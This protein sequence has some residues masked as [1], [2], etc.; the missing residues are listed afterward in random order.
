MRF[1]RKNKKKIIL[2]PFFSLCLFSCSFYDE[3]VRGYFEYW[4]GTVQVGRIDVETPHKKIGS[5]ENVSAKD[6]TEFSLCIINAQSYPL[7]EKPDGGGSCC[8]I[9]DLEENTAFESFEETLVSSDLVSVKA[10]LLDENEGKTLVLKGNLYPKDMSQLW[11]E[12]EFS[13]SFVQN[14]PPDEV[15]NLDATKKDFLGN[16]QHYVSFR[17]P[18]QSRKRNQ[19]ISHYEIGCYLKENGS[20]VFKGKTAVPPEKNMNPDRTSNEFQ[21]CFPFQEENL[22]YDYTVTAVDR[23]NLKSETIS[24]DP[25]IGVK[26]AAEAKI[27]FN[28]EPNGFSDSDGY[29]YFELDSLSSI[30]CEIKKSDEGDILSGTVDGIPYS[31]NHVG[32]LETG[33]HVIT[34]TIQHDGCRT[35]EI[36][37]KIKVVESIR[38]SIYDFTDAEFSSDVCEPGFKTYDCAAGSESASFNLYSSESGISMSGTVDG[39]P[40]TGPLSSRNLGL[41]PHVIN[42]QICKDMRRTKNEEIKIYVRGIFEE[43]EIS[44][45]ATSTAEF[46]DGYEIMK[47]SYRNYD[48][49]PYVVDAKNDNATVSIKIDGASYNSTGVIDF[50]KHVVDIKLTGT[51]WKTFEMQK[52]IYVRMKTLKLKIGSGVSASH[53]YINPT[54]FGKNTWDLKGW[55]KINELLLFSYEKGSVGVTQGIY[56]EIYDNAYSIAVPLEN[57]SDPVTCM[58][59]E[60][61]RNIGV[62]NDKT[63]FDDKGWHFAGSMNLREIKANGWVLE[64]PILNGQN[65][66][67]IKLKFQFFPVEDD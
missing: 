48:K 51:Y 28:I 31:G 62:G 30:T 29:E 59:S 37:K 24:T 38:S 7:L 2:I 50:G 4:T 6:G 39:E 49:M 13:W 60:I 17:I 22:Y 8:T 20:L 18:D 63:L 11:K 45:E 55:I 25:A 67:T 16:R 12:T 3:K 15:S 19:D 33:A 21:Y 56:N 32:E 14:S 53:Y 41:G 23:T 52:K 1:I 42:V 40:F 27:I 54:G 64:T 26:V 10:R 65:G 57:P 58:V 35:L 47:F 34:A 36:T 66:R 5:M 61:R 9:T 46:D 44:F 43:P